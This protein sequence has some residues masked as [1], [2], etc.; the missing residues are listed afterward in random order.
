MEIEKILAKASTYIHNG[1]DISTKY[2]EIEYANVLSTIQ[3]LARTKPEVLDTLRQEF[4]GHY[5]V[6]KL[7]SGKAKGILN[8]AETHTSKKKNLNRKRKK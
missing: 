2:K 3:E 7:N 8:L 5:I 4:L 6:Y 1:V